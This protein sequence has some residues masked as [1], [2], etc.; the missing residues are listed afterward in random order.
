M[1]DK[2]QE[3][4]DRLRVDNYEYEGSVDFLEE[5]LLKNELRVMEEDAKRKSNKKKMVK[6]KYNDSSIQD[7]I[8]ELFLR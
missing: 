4:R 6:P 2:E 8:E 7:A 1:A 3:F 5:E